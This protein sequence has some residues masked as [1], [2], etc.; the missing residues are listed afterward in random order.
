MALP[1]LDVDALEIESWYGLEQDEGEITAY[2]PIQSVEPDGSDEMPASREVDMLDI[3]DENMLL[4]SP[5]R[6]GRD[7]EDR[8]D[9]NMR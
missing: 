1:D 9:N 3:A 8:C 2:I 7:D 4:S 5:V 6:R